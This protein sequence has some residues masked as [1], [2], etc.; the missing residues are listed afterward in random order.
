MQLCDGASPEE[1]QR[2]LL[3]DG[4]SYSY[5]N[6]SDVYTL[7]GVSNA[8]EFAHTRHSMASVGITAQQQDEVFCILSALLHLG[9]VSWQDPHA[10]D[11]NGH[12]HANGNGVGTTL[13]NGTAEAAAAAAESGG[14]L[15]APRPES[16]AALA[17]A[18]R[19]MG[20]E[21]QGLARALS[22]RTRMTPDGPITSPLEAKA[23]ASNRDALVKVIYAR[24]FDWLVARINS[25]IGQDPAAAASIGLLDIY[26]FE[27]FQFND[28]EQFCIN[29]A[30]E[31]LQQH[32]N[33]HVFKWEQVCGLWLGSC[34]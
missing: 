17:A 6:Q 27:S 11:S 28:L 32:F 7:P 4:P 5:L 12:A 25:S 3:A 30:N 20:V 26:G 19:L 18:A 10:A 14:C 33:Q 8:T 13:C 9:N 34:C 23:S 1:K 21:V 24:L 16:P 31:K 22:T 15:L 2:W 29:L